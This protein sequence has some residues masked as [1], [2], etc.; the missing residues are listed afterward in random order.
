LASSTIP[1]TLFDVPSVQLPF[2]IEMQALADFSK[3][4]PTQASMVSSLLSQ[5][6]PAMA[7]MTPVL[8]LLNVF[9]ALKDFASDPLG[10]AGP[11][12][13]ALEN[14]LKLLDPLP[15]VEAVK[16]ILLLVIAYLQSFIQTMSGLLAFQSSIDFSIA[17]G[18][19]N[20]LASL[21]QASNNASVSIQ[22][23]MLSLGPLAPV[24][25][26]IQTFIGVAG[27]S[28]ALPSIA[29]LKAEK[30]TAQALQTLSSMLSTLQQALEGLP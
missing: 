25:T 1:L 29:D 4:P 2:G 7:A 8:S 22:Q 11:L 16:S 27:I 14:A 28:I 6:M 23:M 17:A 3:G 9:S 30:D 10:N 20:L 18:N 5:V 24:M 21:Q 15:F 13:A 12:I 26:L 19:P